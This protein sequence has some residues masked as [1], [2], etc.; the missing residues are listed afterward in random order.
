MVAG[1]LRARI[2]QEIVA[3]EVPDG[4]ESKQVARNVVTFRSVN[5]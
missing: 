2:D 5:I 4:R 3:Q 1:E